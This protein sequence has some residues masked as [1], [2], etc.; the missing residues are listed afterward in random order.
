MASS[1]NT[2]AEEFITAHKLTAQEV[3]EFNAVGITIDQIRGHE[4]GHEYFILGITSEEVGNRHAGVQF[5]FQ[6][7]E[8]EFKKVVH[9][10]GEPIGRETTSYALEFAVKVIYEV[11]PASRQVKKGTTDK[12][13]K[14]RFVVKAGGKNT[15]TTV[16]I[17]SFKNA[18][19]PLA[20]PTV[21][22]NTLLLTMKQA[23]LLA[24]STFANAIQLCII[25]ELVLMTPLCG[26]I[27]SKNNVV[28]LGELIH[29]TLDGDKR[30]ATLVTLSQSCQSGGHY[31]NDSVCAVA[32]VAAVC[33]TRNMTDAKVRDQIITKTYKQYVASGK[34]F[35]AALY[36]SL[37]KY[38]TGGVPAEHSARRL[39]DRYE[40]VQRSIPSYQALRAIQTSGIKT[41]PENVSV[42]GSDSD[43]TVGKN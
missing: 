37:C 26:A 12:K 33:A 8:A 15:L 41:V 30:G 43:S 4:T 14:F 20:K 11:E 16:Y 40:A 21:V 32:V 36:E 39:V 24:Q 6:D 34:P 19:P 2:T 13:W 22:Q 18:E 29:P 31:L 27:F 23:S 17:A 42:Y 5:D 9:D 28:E 35:D 1:T 3:T 10:Y 38:A 7:L 25:D